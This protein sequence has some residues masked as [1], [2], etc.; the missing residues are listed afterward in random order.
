MFCCS[1]TS[2]P[3]V[4]GFGPL[5]GPAFTLGD[6]GVERVYLLSWTASTRASLACNVSIVQ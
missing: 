4:W 6:F 3:G 2:R 5:P 1:V